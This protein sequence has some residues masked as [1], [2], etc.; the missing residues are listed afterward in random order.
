MV[1][2]WGLKQGTRVRLEGNT[3]AE[4][5]A[6]TEDGQWVKVRYAQVPDNP[7][8]VGTEDLCSVDEIVDIA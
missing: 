1:D 6:E 3:I 7:A 8:I 4:I 5:I 2:I